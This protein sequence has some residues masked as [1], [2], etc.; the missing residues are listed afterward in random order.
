MV[1]GSPA[2]QT[3]H[4]VLLSA[5]HLQEYS[6]TEV[7]ATHHIIVMNIGKRTVRYTTS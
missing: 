7:L 6:Y 5:A 3:S 1:C 2:T 4:G